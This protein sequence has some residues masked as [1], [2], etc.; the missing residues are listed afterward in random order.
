MLSARSESVA[1]AV[2]GVTG[3]GKSSFIS[4]LAD[5]RVEISHGLHSGEHKTGEGVSRLTILAGTVDIAVYSFTDGPRGTVFLVDTPGFDD[6]TRSDAEILKDISYFLASMYH[7]RIRLAGIIYLHPIATARMGGSAVKNLLMFKALCGDQSFRHVTFATTMWSEMEANDTMNLGNKRQLELEEN[8][9]AEMIRL[10]SIVKKHNRGRSTAIEIVR[11]LTTRADTSIILAIQRQLV[12]ERRTLED[13]DAGKVVCDE[14]VLAKE[15][16]RQ[17]LADLRE[18]LEEAKRDNDR[19]AIEA[20][21]GDLAT[22][23]ARA[24]QRMRDGDSLEVDIRELAQEQRPRYHRLITSLQQQRQGGVG[25]E[26]LSETEQQM[27]RVRD[28][29][30]RLQKQALENESLKKQLRK[31]GSGNAADRGPEILQVVPRRSTQDEKYQGIIAQ[32]WSKIGSFLGVAEDREKL[33][34]VRRSA[35][36]RSMPDAEPHS[37]LSDVADAGS[38]R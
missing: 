38:S 25:R 14:I 35:T 24:R 8:Y 9:W 36:S 17:E 16:F 2:M 15:K 27:A 28:L 7:N 5:Q 20:L 1:I 4:L 26:L 22:T 21:R 12:D 33:Y 13:T 19:D 37:P 18:S 6:T 29:E 10:G 32:F 3:S 23:E 30:R 31:K 34:F 11:M